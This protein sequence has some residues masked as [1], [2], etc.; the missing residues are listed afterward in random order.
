[1]KKFVLVGLLFCS[2]ANAEIPVEGNSMGSSQKIYAFKEDNGTTL[3]TIKKPK[4]SK[5]GNN[6]E[7]E[8]LKNE[9]ADFSQITL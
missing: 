3:L 2:V 4:D 7:R 9:D 5:L 6:Y 1:M 8:I